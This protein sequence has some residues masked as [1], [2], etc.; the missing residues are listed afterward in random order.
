MR[1]PKRITLC[2][3]QIEEIWN[4]NPDLRFG[5]LLS[6]MDMVSIFY[7]EDNKLFDLTKLD[8]PYFIDED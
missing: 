3:K 7:K 2:L 1:N 5:Q 8:G 4:V 6:Y